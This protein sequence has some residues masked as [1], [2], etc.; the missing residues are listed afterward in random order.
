MRTYCNTTTHFADSHVTFQ[1]DK[2]RSILQNAV[3]KAGVSSSQDQVD[4]KKE[5]FEI[6]MMIVA[7][8]Y[9]QDNHK[10]CLHGANIYYKAVKAFGASSYAKKQKS[11]CTHDCAKKLG[12]PY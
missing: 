7:W 9:I 11:V 6:F 8:R 2:L 4:L 10:A 3:K 5:A 1:K 12:H